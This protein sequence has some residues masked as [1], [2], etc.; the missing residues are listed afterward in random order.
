LFSGRNTGVRRIDRYLAGEIGVPFAAALLFLFMLL[1]AMQLL[2]GIEVLFGSGVK[3]LDLFRIA[4]YLAPHFLV[5]AAPAALLFAVVLGVGRWS[6]DRETLA[7]FAS[8]VSPLR[9]WLAPAGVALLVSVLGVG[10]SHTLEPKGL[11]SLKLHVNEL[12]K[13]NMAGDVKPGVFY[14]ALSDMTLYA[15]G[16]SPETRKFTNVLIADHRDDRAPMLLLARRGFVDPFG[17]G[18]G[19]RMLLSDGEIHR[20]SAE[21]ED[22]AVVGFEEATLNVAVD[23]DLLRG[24]KFGSASNEEM[25]PDELSESARR[26]EAA[27]QP[28]EARSYEVARARRVASP[29]S[30]LAFALCG[31]PLA[32]GQRRGG[33]T[34]G[35]VAT[36]LAFIGY[37][38]VAR[39]AELLAEGGAL[40]PSV[41][42]HLPNVAFALVAVL[43]MRRAQGLKG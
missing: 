1:F 24:N 21:G 5:M 12:I 31:V 7:L 28:N 40:R 42:A 38:I 30:A 19:L 43:L 23:R 39:G 25:T 14:D 32:L 8:G 29:L 4:G 6:E 11:A 41:A 22:Y 2:K 16:V 13:R 34:L 17:G 27:G 36:L 33:R 15:Q 18:S 35:A 10:L 37:Y 9:L 20:S 26:A 3:P